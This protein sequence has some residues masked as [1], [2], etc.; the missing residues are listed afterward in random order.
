MG[1]VGGKILE[2]KEMI[3]VVRCAAAK[4]EIHKYLTD[5]DVEYWEI[6]GCIVRGDPGDKFYPFTPKWNEE[7][8]KEWIQHRG[9][10]TQAGALKFLEDWQKRK[11]S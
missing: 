4:W 8:G 10:S 2:R 7:K 5:G 11:M 1:C 6:I 3:R 9:F